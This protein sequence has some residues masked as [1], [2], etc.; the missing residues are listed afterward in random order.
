MSASYSDPVAAAFIVIPVLLALALAWG[1][2]VAWRRS[3]AWASPARRVS[4]ITTGAAVAWMASTWALAA[5]GVFRQWER[6]PPPFAL[7]VVAIVA[8]AIG[9]AFSRLG[10]RIARFL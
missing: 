8:L 2:G 7:L 10:L 3:G 6:M 5:S 9:M 1:A 4:V